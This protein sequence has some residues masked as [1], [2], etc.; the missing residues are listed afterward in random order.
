MFFLQVLPSVVIA[1]AGVYPSEEQWFSF[2]VEQNGKPVEIKNNR[3]SIEKA[4][5]T[6]VLITRGPLGVLVN[7][8]EKDTLYKGFLKNKPLSEFLPQPD[9]FMGL[10]EEDFNPDESIFIDEFSAHYLYFENRTRHRFSTAE[11]SDGYV[12]GRRIISNYKTYTDAESIIP[13]SELETDTLYLGFMYGEWD[14]N[15]NRIELQKE[16][17]KVNFR[18]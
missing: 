10:G 8:S 17:V 13:I 5:F 1:Q 15:F 2:A 12:T 11:L 4:P 3:L 6:L 16:A 18:D 9:L 7:F 14:E